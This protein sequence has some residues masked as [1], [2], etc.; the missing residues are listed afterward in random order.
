VARRRKRKDKK[1]GF[2]LFRLHPL[3]FYNIEA[4]KKTFRPQPHDYR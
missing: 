3:T 2:I 4:I 1:N